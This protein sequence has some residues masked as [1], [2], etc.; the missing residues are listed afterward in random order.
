MKYLVLLDG[1]IEPT[2]VAHKC[3]L[4]KSEVTLSKAIRGFDD[5]QLHWPLISFVHWIPRSIKVVRPAL[6]FYFS[7]LPLSLFVIDGVLESLVQYQNCHE[8][9]SR[10]PPWNFILSFHKYF[11]AESF[12]FTIFYLIS[13]EKK[14]FYHQSIIKIVEAWKKPFNLAHTPTH[15]KKPGQP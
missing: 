3:S 10:E 7:L 4:Y 13:I 8:P 14:S 9:P 11:F 15:I 12:H 1:E 6:T 2:G 5:C